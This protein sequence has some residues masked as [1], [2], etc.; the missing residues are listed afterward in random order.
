MEMGICVSN[1]REVGNGDVVLKVS[2]GPLG[3]AEVKF[4]TNKD[5]DRADLIIAA[6]EAYHAREPDETID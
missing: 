3:P 1:A 6:A 5:M 4:T 2:E